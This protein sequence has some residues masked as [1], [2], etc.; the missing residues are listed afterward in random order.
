MGAAALRQLTVGFEDQ[1]FVDDV[2]SVAFDIPIDNYRA[3][4]QF[5]ADANRRE[6]F[7]FLTRVEI[8]ENVRQIPFLRAEDGGMK[9]QRWRQRS[10]Q[11]RSVAIPRIIVTGSGDV[12][13]DRG[14]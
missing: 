4:A 9:Y 1:R 10:A 3:A 12:I 8:A 7:P 6:A 11:R 5:L 13:L 14:G 2:F